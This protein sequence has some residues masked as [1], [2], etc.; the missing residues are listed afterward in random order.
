M[1]AGIS[2]RDVLRHGG[3]AAAY[4]IA[5]PPATPPTATLVPSALT[6]QASAQTF[7]IIRADR[8]NAPAWTFGRA[9]GHDDETRLHVS[10]Q[11]GSTALVTGSLEA[12]GSALGLDFSTA[13][14]VGSGVQDLAALF[15]NSVLGTLDF[16]LAPTKGGAR[17]DT[18]WM[19]LGAGRL[20]D[21]GWALVPVYVGLQQYSGTQDDNA[22]KKPVWYPHLVSSSTA[23]A[24]SQGGR[25]G[26]D[27]ADLAAKAGMPS[28]SRLFLDI[29]TVGVAAPAQPLRPAMLAYIEAWRAKVSQTAYEPAFYGLPRVCDQLH[30]KYPA[31][32]IYASRGWYSVPVNDGQEPKASPGQEVSLD[33]RPIPLAPPSGKATDPGFAFTSYAQTW[34]WCVDWP[35][36]TADVTH[37]PPLHRLPL[38]RD[39]GERRDWTLPGS[40]IDFDSSRSPDPGLT[41]VQHAGPGGPATKTNRR[42]EVARIVASPATVPA[43]SSLTLRVHL[44]RAA[45]RDAAVPVLLSASVPELAVPTAVRVPAGA[46]SVDVSVSTVPVDQV[47]RGTISA[48]TLHQLRTLPA[49]AQV[50]VT[51]FS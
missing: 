42:R 26:Q 12:L 11:R 21:Q 30:A 46:V 41:Q 50:T 13:P 45:P 22:G 9:R 4:W 37:N 19:K 3:L 14:P 24:K 15:D 5:P 17:V 31:V 29:E 7:G 39:T 48:R 32:A 33:P 40:A 6:P 38:F 2:R 8:V 43:G 23:T 1:S 36:R 16:Y 28:G 51:P 10:A 25:D 47:V 20:L 44:T 35:G 49:R 34:Q 18:S 27:A